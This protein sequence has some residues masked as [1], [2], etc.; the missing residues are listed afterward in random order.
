[1]SK[2]VTTKQES[3]LPAAPM[4]AWGAEGI[5]AED[6]LLPRLML[7]QPLSEFVTAGDA[8]MGTIVESLD[9]T[10]VMGGEKEPCELIIFGQFKTWRIEHDGE[11]E[12]TIPWTPE[13]AGLEYESEVDG[14]IVKNQQVINYYGLSV[15]DIAK[16]EAFPYVIAFKGNSKNTGK[17]LGALLMKLQSQNKPSAAKVFQITTKKDSNDKGTFFVFEVAP[18][19]DTTQEEMAVTYKWY[20]QL[21][22]AKVHVDG[23][24]DEKIVEEAKPAPKTSSKGKPVNDMTV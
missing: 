10:K 8:K 18:G 19:R 24:E 3:N 20:Q 21:A 1:M 5:T 11:Y 9:K 13:N 16:G 6:I 15:K 23:D 2:Q 14:V 12:K 7:M 17:A 22:T 4:G